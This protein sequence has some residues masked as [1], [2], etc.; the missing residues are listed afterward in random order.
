MDQYTVRQIITPQVA[1]EFLA[2]SDAAKLQ[3]NIEIVNRTL[4][5]TKVA[6][7]ARVMRNGLWDGRSHQGIAISPEGFLI[8][9]Q[10]RMWAV[11]ESLA[12][13]EMLVTYNVPRE[14]QAV[15]DDGMRRT[16]YDFS[17]FTKIHAS[18]ARLLASSSRH[19]TNI[20]VNELSETYAA[21]I[22]FCVGVG[23]SGGSTHVKK[24]TVAPVYAAVARAYYTQDRVRLRE[25]LGVMR[26]GRTDRPDQDGAAIALREWLLSGHTSVRGSK[27]IV[28]EIQG[29][30]TYCLLAFLK[31]ADVKRVLD[32]D[33]AAFKIIL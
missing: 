21:A 6:E 27:E 11:S 13:V 9:G 5:N 7:Y 12:T 3:Y 17:R 24:V 20:E 22:E 1:E 25:F 31:R 19:Q 4:R 23:E 29:K 28:R 8:D 16:A 14:V 18:I 32:T 30:T 10:H 2:R 15:M 33:P 26:T